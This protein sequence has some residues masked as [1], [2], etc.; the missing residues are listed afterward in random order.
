VSLPDSLGS[1][2]RVWLPSWR[3]SP[4]EAWPIL[5]QVGSARGIRP[6]KLSPLERY[7]VRFR[8]KAPTCRFTHR[9]A[10]RRRRAGPMVRGSWALPLS[11]VPCCT[12]GVS[13]DTTGCSLGLTPFR[14]YQRKPR[15]GFR[16]ISSHA[17]TVERGSTTAA[18]QSFSELSPDLDPLRFA[19][20][21]PEATLLGFRACTLPIMQASAIRA[22]CSPLAAP[23][24]TVDWPTIFGSRQRLTG[25]VGTA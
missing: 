19:P 16:L 14:V 23:C 8:P 9:Y 25:V 2:F 21:K 20:H 10:H 4:F 24:I 5:F 6:S 15:P 13:T 17:L 12:C 11:R 3:F 22:M 18:P 1:A 7:S